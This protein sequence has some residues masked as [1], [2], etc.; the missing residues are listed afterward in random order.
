MIRIIYDKYKKLAMIYL[1]SIIVLVIVL[2]GLKNE[3]IKNIVEYCPVPINENSK[4]KWLLKLRGNNY[5]ITKQGLKSSLTKNCLITLWGI[6]HA[7]LYSIIGYCCPDMFLE[8]FIIGVGFETWEVILMDC[9][10]VLDIVWN[11]IGF[12]IGYYI[13]A[14]R[15]S[16]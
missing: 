5:Q 10:D 15:F 11:S 12:M 13:Q 7:A 16:K 1:I 3:K 4:H 14:Y 8:S 6:S 9:H 2:A